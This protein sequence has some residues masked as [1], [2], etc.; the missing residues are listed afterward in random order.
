VLY[1]RIPAF[2]SRSEVEARPKLIVHKLEEEKENG[3]PEDANAKK[4]KNA[5]NDV[6][7]VQEKHKNKFKL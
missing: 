6:E 3:K 4:Q 5:E 1:W 7:N 2:I